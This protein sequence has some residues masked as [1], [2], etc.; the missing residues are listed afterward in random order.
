MRASHLDRLSSVIT[1][2][3]LFVYLITG[4]TSYHNSTA[5]LIGLAVI[6]CCSSLPVSICSTS[7]ASLP[8]FLSFNLAATYSPTPSPVQYHRPLRSLPSCS[9]WER[10]CPLSASP[11]EILFGLFTEPI[12]FISSFARLALPQIR[13][14]SFR[15][16]QAFTCLIPVSNDSA[17]KFASS[18]LQS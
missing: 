16:I 12:I 13:S 18:F 7:A 15:Q 2:T 14:A 1:Y 10:V 11:P 4:E 5:L 17:N 6:S 3:N 9:G 8:Q